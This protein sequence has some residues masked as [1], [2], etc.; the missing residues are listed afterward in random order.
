MTVKQNMY[1]HN[2]EVLGVKRATWAFEVNMGPA[3]T[4]AASGATAAQTPSGYLLGLTM[5]GENIG[6]GT[7]VATAGDLD[8]MTVDAGHAT[9]DGGA[10]GWV[11]ANSKIELRELQ[12]VS[13]NDFTTKLEFSATASASEVVYACRTYYLDAH[14]STNVES[15]QALLEGLGDASGGYEDSWVLKGGQIEQPMTITFENGGLP[16]LGFNFTFADWEHGDDAALTPAALAIA[17][18]SNLNEIPIVDSEFRCGVV[19][20]ASITNTEF[21]IS[22]FNVELGYKYQPLR[23][24]G[25]TNN[26]VQWV[27]VPDRPVVQGSF[28]IPFEYWGEGQTFRDH[29]EAKDDLYIMF[30]IGSTISTGSSVQCG[31]MLISIPTIQITDSQ[32]VDMD[33]LMGEQVSFKGRLDGDTTATTAMAN[34]PFRIHIF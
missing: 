5:G 28:T 24:P 12:V 2:E 27:M 20:T 15:L 8:Q 34:S 18:Y 3:D 11:N 31:A 23:S 22:E 14:T 9:D 13:T 26:I 16:K 29:M 6:V 30:Q 10:I 1:D 32:R 4:T 25:G 19:G 33:G 21:H 7:S 17:S